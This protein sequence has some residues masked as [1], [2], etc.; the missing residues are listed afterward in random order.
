LNLLRL[1]LEQLRAHT[2]LEKAVSK[3][4]RL[5]LRRL[6]RRLGLRRGP[7]CLHGKICR[8]R[9]HFL[10]VAA[11]WRRGCGVCALL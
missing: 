7:G 11:A 2:L 9:C 4:E 10:G 6:G 8:C 5:L 3:D 1:R